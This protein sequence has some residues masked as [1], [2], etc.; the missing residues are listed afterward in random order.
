GGASVD[1]SSRSLV[2][3]NPKRIESLENDPDRCPLARENHRFA[4]EIRELH[5]GLA[6]RPTHRII[7]SIR[8]DAVVVLSV[9][10]AA[11]QDLTEDDLP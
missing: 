1:R 10:H 3:W 4:Y 8:P 6:S 7:F 9:R 11:Q 5:F 2:H